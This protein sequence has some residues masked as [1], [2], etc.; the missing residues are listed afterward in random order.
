MKNQTTTTAR[1]NQVRNFAAGL[2]TSRNLF[3]KETIKPVMARFR[4][5]HY[6]ASYLL[7]LID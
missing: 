1:R 4:I 2:Q 7:G 6:R 3:L 5:S